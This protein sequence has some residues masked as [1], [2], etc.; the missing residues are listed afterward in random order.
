M[1][2]P[3]AESPSQTHASGLSYPEVVRHRVAE[4]QSRP[5]SALPISLESLL[6]LDPA[7]PSLFLC[8][9]LVIP[10]AWQYYLTFSPVRCATASLLTFV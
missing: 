3:P 10:V 4:N 5:P 8:N 7:P 1:H 2:D 9:S 6:Y